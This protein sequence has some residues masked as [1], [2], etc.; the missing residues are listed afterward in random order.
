MSKAAWPSGREVV[1]CDPVAVAGLAIMSGA[2]DAPYADD[3]NPSTAEIAFWDRVA[4]E[5]ER[6]AS[7]AVQGLS[8]QGRAV[9]AEE[10][11]DLLPIAETKLAQLQALGYTINGFALWRDG[12]RGFIDYAGFVGWHHPNQPSAPLPPSPPA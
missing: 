5:R 4:E 6:I 7:W 1:N 10:V 11:P 9:T 12:K 3:Q 2:R 8:I